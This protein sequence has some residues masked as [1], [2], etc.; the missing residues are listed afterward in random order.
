MTAVFYCN[1]QVPVM[2]YKDA[3]QGVRTHLIRHIYDGTSD[4]SFVSEAKADLHSGQVSAANDKFEHLTCFAGGMFVLGG[5]CFLLAGCRYRTCISDSDCVMKHHQRLMPAQ[6]L[7]A[8]GKPLR[9]C[10]LEP[11]Q[12]HSGCT[13]VVQAS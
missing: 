5:Y 3:M 12:S 8:A 1:L 13:T 4:M 9:C 2:L 11:D 6:S 10:M 7:A